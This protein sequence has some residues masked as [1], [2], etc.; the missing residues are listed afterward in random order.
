MIFAVAAGCVLAGF[1]IGC[2]AT[3]RVSEYRLYTAHAKGLFH[4]RNER[5]WEVHRLRNR[6]THLEAQAR[7]LV[8]SARNKG[9]AS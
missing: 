4:G 7:E 2:F 5:E 6:V 9:A 1:L 3:E 8:P